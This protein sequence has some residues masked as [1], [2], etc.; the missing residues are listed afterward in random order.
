MHRNSTP[1]YKRSPANSNARGTCSGSSTSHGSRT[2]PSKLQCTA[3]RPHA[4]C[5]NRIRQCLIVYRQECARPWILPCM[6]MHRFTDA[7]HMHDALAQGRCSGCSRRRRARVQSRCCRWRSTS[8]FWAHLH[9]SGLIPCHIRTGTGPTLATSCPGTLGLSQV[10]LLWP[11]VA[12][13]RTLAAD[14]RRRRYGQRVRCCAVRCAVEC[15]CSQWRGAKGCTIC[16]S[17]RHVAGRIR[18]SHA[19]YDIVKHL[20]SFYAYVTRA[21]CDHS[22][23]LVLTQ[24]WQCFRRL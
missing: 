10:F 15:R 11:H 23:S 16:H 6:H 13:H 8:A 5:A 1:A 21:K 20:T 3:V 7:Q 4:P 14:A 9:R 22:C 18:V 24:M 2:C 12:R 19:T 17:Q